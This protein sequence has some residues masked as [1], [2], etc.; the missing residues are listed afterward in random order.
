MPLQDQVEKLLLDTGKGCSI[1]G[2]TPVVNVDATY[3]LCGGCV[4]ERLRDDNYMTTLLRVIINQ[5]QN[6]PK[7][8]TAER[9]SDAANA[10]LESLNNAVALE[11][12][13][14][15]TAIDGEPEC[16]SSGGTTGSSGAA[17]FP[18]PRA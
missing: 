12:N 5:A 9:I 4:N 1:C 14:P 15:V 17:P 2:K 13:R 11:Q 18:S 7:S 16:S 6:L 3:W 10:L 8:A